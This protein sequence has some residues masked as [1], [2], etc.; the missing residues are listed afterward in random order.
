M[1]TR[2]ARM[3]VAQL[4]RASGVTVRT[5]HHYDD[6]GLLK[7]AHVGRNGYRY[8]GRAEALRLQQILF[9]RELGV[10]L[11]S[12]ERLLA[13]DGSDQIA[14]LMRRRDELE[15][16]RDRYRLL[17]ETIDRTISDLRG[18]DLQDED[19]MNIDHW[20]RGFSPEKQAGYEDWLVDRYGERMRED[21]ATASG[22]VN[23]MTGPDR[24]A[25]MRDLQ[26]IETE[27]ADCLRAGEAADSPRA[28]L[29]LDRH[30]EWVS[31]MWGRPCSLEA[32][33]GLADIYL[34]HPDFRSRY[35]ALQVGF[36][37]WLHAAMKAFAA[38]A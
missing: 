11:S 17:I 9:H 22:A 35:E 18:A 1:V 13:A 8:Y 24:Q 15:A 2:I 26:T 12:I 25:M 10:P 36:A 20:Y 38:R 6:I 4:A 14:L 29:A 21:L 19:R 27:L 30:R 23:A 31:R 7:P 37:V 3:T 28:R 32:Y 5:L 33:S 16:E 34:E